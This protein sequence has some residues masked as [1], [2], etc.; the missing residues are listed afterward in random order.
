[1]TEN[2]SISIAVRITP[3]EKRM[4]ESLGSTAS[5]AIRNAI[6]LLNPHVVHR[7]VPQDTINVDRLQRTTEKNNNH[8]SKPTAQQKPP[9]NHILEWRCGMLKPVK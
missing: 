1:M 4:L 6:S 7:H 3:Q 5:E 2:K 8:T 9:A